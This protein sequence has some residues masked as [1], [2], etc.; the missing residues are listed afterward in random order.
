MKETGAGKGR[1]PLGGNGHLRLPSMETLEQGLE[2]AR[3][4]VR[5]AART[6]ASFVRERPGT[7]LVVALGAGYIVGRLLR[8]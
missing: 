8:K 1:H 5:E 4:R 2:A 7:S 3:E 6:V